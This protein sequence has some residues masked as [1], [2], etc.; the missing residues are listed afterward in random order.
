M[1][2]RLMSDQRVHAVAVPDPDQARRPLG[3]VTSTGIFEAPSA[4]ALYAASARPEGSHNEESQRRLVDRCIAAVAAAA[5]T[6]VPKIAIAKIQAAGTR[7]LRSPLAI[8]ASSA[9]APMSPVLLRNERLRM[10]TPP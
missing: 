10:V 2:A 6:S 7:L 5:M 4:I 8:S 9:M 1:V 3:F